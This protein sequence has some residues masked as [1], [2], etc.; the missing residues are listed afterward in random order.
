MTLPICWIASYPKSGNT[1]V[2]FLL[3]NY[4]FGPVEQSEAIA[5]TIPDLHICGTDLAG[6]EV[7]ETLLVKTHFMPDDKLLFAERTTRFVYIVRHPRDVLRSCMN[8]AK[9]LMP[10]EEARMVTPQI[11]ARAFLK[12]GGEPFFLRFG[13]GTV[14]QHVRGWL[15]APQWE[16]VVVRYEDLKARPER[17]LSRMLRLLGHEPDMERVREAVASSEFSRVKKL[18]EK[19]KRAGKASSVF[20]GDAKTLAK[21]HQFMNKGEIGRSLDEIIPG[22]EEAVSKRFAH[23]I[24]RFGY[25]DDTSDV[26]AG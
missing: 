14:E 25:A 21:G 2:R 10:P 12:F 18:E 6:R 5:E 16:H 17:E 19:E 1:W 22:L 24:E 11:Y 20:A 3:H 23:V 26:G 8:Y 9:M 13:F 4:F 15:D 7:C